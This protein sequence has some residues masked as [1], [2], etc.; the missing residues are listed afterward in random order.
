MGPMNME[1]SATSAT[2][3]YLETVQLCDDHK[4]R[5]NSWRTREPG[6]NEFISALAAGMKAELIVEIASCVSPSTIA[7]AT[8][9]RLTGARFV[10]ILP[11]TVLAEAKKVIKDS[12]LKD[13]VEFTTGD[14]FEIL[15]NYENIDF[16]L[17]D[18]KD[19]NYRK[20]LK[21]LD[22]NERKA[23]VV[24]NNLVAAKEGV[25][26]HLRGMKDKATV[27]SLK[28]PIGRGMEITTIARSNKTG[29]RNL[30]DGQSHSG[31]EREGTSMKKSSGGKSKW[32][33]R[34][35]EESG[36]EHIFR[37]LRSDDIYTAPMCI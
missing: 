9:A 23:M 2:K 22:V 28:C 26:G 24:A 27:R 18:C 8:A 32:I 19:D 31:A 12:G 7:L 16:C 1:W 35:D 17:V 5:C 15:Q 11:E 37:V 36:E 33:F 21:L 30:G 34:T 10:C 20:L 29:R 4:R 3:A 14:P 6:S 25:G 13:I